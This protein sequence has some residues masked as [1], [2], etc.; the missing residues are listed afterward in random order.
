VFQRTGPLFTVATDE[1]KLW[2]TERNEG[3]SMRNWLAFSIAIAIAV[4]PCCSSFAAEEEKT[5]GVKASIAWFGEWAGGLEAAKRS[6]RPI[7]LIAAAPHCHQI[8]GMW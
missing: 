3:D 4:F 7:L 1:D 5:D 8:S 2:I 6:G